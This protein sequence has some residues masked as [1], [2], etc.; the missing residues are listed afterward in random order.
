MKEYMAK[1]NATSGSLKTDVQ[2]CEFLKDIPTI[3][4][5]SRIHGSG[6]EWR[7]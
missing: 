7:M 4:F 2:L 1:N 5:L 3:F 6:I